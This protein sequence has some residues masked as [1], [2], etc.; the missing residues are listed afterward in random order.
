MLA[1]MW[2][3]P[4]CYCFEA[5]KRESLSN[6]YSL[7]WTS[8]AVSFFRANSNRFKWFQRPLRFPLLKWS[9]DA[10]ECRWRKWKNWIISPV[11]KQWNSEE[12]YPEGYIFNFLKINMKIH[13][14]LPRKEPPKIASGAFGVNVS[15]GFTILGFCHDFKNFFY[16]Y[17]L[18]D[19]MSDLPQPCFPHKTGY[20]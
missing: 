8:T 5:I 13:I 2:L 19:N 14:Y 10:S 15:S 9:G 18:G 3:F 7:S 4:I 1:R 6:E 17:F 20:F 11:L 12:D 16:C